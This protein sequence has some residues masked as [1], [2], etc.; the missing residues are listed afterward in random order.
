MANH[1]WAD[2]SWDKLKSKPI[3]LYNQQYFSDLVQEFSLHVD[4]IPLNH[5]VQFILNKTQ[6]SFLYQKCSP[7]IFLVPWNKTTGPYR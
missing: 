7:Q 5:M 6:F 4:Y 2:F 1:L 3:P